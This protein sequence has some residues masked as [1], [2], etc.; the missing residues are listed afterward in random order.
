MFDFNFDSYDA[1][2]PTDRAALAEKVREMEAQIFK[3]LDANG[4]NPFTA[5]CV[6]L[7]GLIHNLIVLRSDVSAED[8]ANFVYRQTLRISH[9][10][11]AAMQGMENKG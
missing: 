2:S 7:F 4:I 6:L 10:T 5:H 3:L 8:I 9:E 11:L 1:S